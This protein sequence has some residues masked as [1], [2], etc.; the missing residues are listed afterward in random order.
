MTLYLSQR[1]IYKLNQA[2]MKIRKAYFLE[3]RNEGIFVVQYCW[4]VYN[5]M[6]STSRQQKCKSL[7]GTYL[8]Q[9]RE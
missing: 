5:D 3:K 7:N 6:S 9:I 4:S 1:K 8:Q 2:R